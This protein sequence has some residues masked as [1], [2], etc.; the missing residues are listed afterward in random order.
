[1]DK[2]NLVY[3]YIHSGI[4]FSLKNEG[5]TVNCEHMYNH[6]EHCVC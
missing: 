3:L 5:N 2:E 1:M 4:L 6:K